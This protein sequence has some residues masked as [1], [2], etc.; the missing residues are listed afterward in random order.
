[1]SWMRKSKGPKV[2]NTKLTIFIFV[3]LYA[4]FMVAGSAKAT[5]Q[6]PVDKRPGTWE[7]IRQSRQ[8]QPEQ[9]TAINSKL[10]ELLDK[11]AATQDLLMKSFRIE[12]EET[13]ES[14]GRYSTG[15]RAGVPLYRQKR[16]MR[17][18]LC[19]DGE[20]SKWSDEIWGDFNYRQ[21]GLSRTDAVYRS[22]LW[23]G[24][25]NLSFV[26]K[27]PSS[28][29]PGLLVIDNK[30][31]AS[32]LQNVTTARG[33]Y[34]MGY[35]TGNSKRID[36]VLHSAKSLRV[37]DN[38]DVIGGISCHVI[39]GQT[40]Y[41]HYTIWIDPRHGYNIARAEI[42][43]EKHKR[44]G[45]YLPDWYRVLEN[46]RFEQING[47]WVPMEADITEDE[48]WPNGDFRRLKEHHKRIQVLLN[49]DHE[50]LGYFK[51]DDIENGTKVY[52]APSKTPYIW[53]DGR[54]VDQQ[55]SPVSLGPEEP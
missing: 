5:P 11:Y 38:Q 51:T 15:P 39:E 7:L 30:S 48:N 40:E 10:S 37:R 52:I 2:R 25:R 28:D 32:P 12:Y 54:V 41:N 26:R 14:V 13:S 23:D 47:V 33:E 19:F 31:P 50:A 44:N 36:V 27:R 1:M 16:Y 22:W 46:V 9:K 24:Q 49:P 18:R 42:R 3:L 45:N 55:G 53:R 20:R 21:R 8:K 29:K 4:G 35:F 34:L 6:R 17:G 43:Q